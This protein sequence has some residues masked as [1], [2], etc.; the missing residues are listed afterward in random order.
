MVENAHL[1]IVVNPS[2]KI[3]STKLEDTFKLLDDFVKEN[4]KLNYDTFHQL[5]IVDYLNCFN[6]KPASW[7][8][9]RISPKDK[10]EVLRN[11][12]ENKKLDYDLNTLYKY[13]LVIPLKN[14]IIVAIYKNN[15]KNIYIF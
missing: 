11:L 9:E 7:W 13:S 5:L 15:T 8:N 1:F 12:Y 2:G 10:N 14:N 4:I 3:T 6:I